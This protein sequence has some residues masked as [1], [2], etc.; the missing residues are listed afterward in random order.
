M[1]RLILFMAIVGFVGAVVFSVLSLPDKKNRPLPIQERVAQARKTGETQ[2][3][4]RKEKAGKVRPEPAPAAAGSARKANDPAP[5]PPA[6]PLSQEELNELRQQ[7]EELNREKKILAKRAMDLEVEL[8]RSEESKQAATEK[9]GLNQLRIKPEESITL[10]IGALFNSGPV[11]LSPS[12][13][14]IL[15][16]VAERFKEKLKSVPKALIRVEGHS[17]NTSLGAAKR[18]LYQDNLGLSAVRAL[19]VARQLIKEGINPRRISVTGFGEFQ[20]TASNK[21]AQGQAK[22]R[23]V[24]IRFFPN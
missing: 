15:T 5:A 19:I 4:P 13:E 12:G 23:R 16:K 24:V 14:K 1:Q 11:E 7:I 9:K 10:T 17:D 8:A 21:T 2:A 18:K 6:E 20:P 3:Q 22:N